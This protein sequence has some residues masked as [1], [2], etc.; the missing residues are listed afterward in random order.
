MEHISLY[1]T[2]LVHF[3][4]LVFLAE[5]SQILASDISLYEGSFQKGL[6]CFHTYAVM[7]FNIAIVNF[8][9]LLQLLKQGACYP[10][11]ICDK[12]R[13]HIRIVKMI[14]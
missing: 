6:V 5:N 3:L 8:K 10:S 2:M 1:V 12:N 11:F 14:R 13:V 9:F 7:Q 4:C